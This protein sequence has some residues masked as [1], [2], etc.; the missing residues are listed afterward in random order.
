MYVIKFHY[1]FDLSVGKRDKYR[2][3]IV[4]TR[5]LPSLIFSIEKN[6]SMASA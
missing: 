2:I 3:A 6:P 5:C 1:Y 4:V